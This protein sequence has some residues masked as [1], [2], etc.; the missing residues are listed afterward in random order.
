MRDKQRFA[1]LIRPNEREILKR[2][3]EAMD[4]SEGATLR[5]LIRQ[6]GKELGKTPARADLPCDK[7]PAEVRP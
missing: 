1:F 2:L 5:T 7:T 4:R 6:A 3:S